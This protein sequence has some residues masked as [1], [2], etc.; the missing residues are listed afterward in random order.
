MHNFPL[1]DAVDV[2]IGVDV[3]KGHHH[4]VA[5]DRNGR[6]LYNKALPNDETQLRALINELKAHG[7]LLFVVDQPATIGALPLAAAGR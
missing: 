3:G 5:L 2:F 7:Q 6:R 4:A 1:H